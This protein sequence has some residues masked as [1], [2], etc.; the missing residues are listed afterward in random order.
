MIYAIVWGEYS[1]WG[2]EGYFTDKEK[3]MEYCRVRNSFSDRPNEEWYYVKEIKPIHVNIKRLQEWKCYMYSVATGEISRLH[4]C[5]KV[6]DDTFTP[7]EVMKRG[8]AY[9]LKFWLREE[10]SYTKALKIASDLWADKCIKGG[11]IIYE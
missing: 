5:D 3:A 4:F 7:F 10:V 11:G 1:D 9:Y 8:A 6:S 2:I